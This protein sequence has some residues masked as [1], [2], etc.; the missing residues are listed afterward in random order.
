[1]EEDGWSAEIGKKMQATA[2]ILSKDRKLRF[3]DQNRKPAAASKES[4]LSY[5]AIGSHH[6][7]SPSKPGIVALDLH[8]SDPNLVL[9]GGMDFN[10]IIFNRTTGKI[11]DTLKGHKKRVTEVKFH[12]DE[13]LILTASADA[14]TMLWQP[15]E[16]GK[17]H[18]S[19]TLSDHKG[20]VTALTLHPSGAYFVT[21]SSDKS[22][23]FYDIETATCRQQVSDEKFAGGYNRIS[24]HPDGLI[25]GA[26]TSDSL[27]RIFDVRARKNVATFKGHVGPVTA[28]AFSQNGYHLSTGDEEGTIKFWDLRK[29]ENFQTVES[30]V[31]KKVNQI[32][33]DSS[34]SYLAVAGNDIKI[35]A[36]N[37]QSSWELVHSYGDHADQVTVVRFG[38]EA[39]F[40]ASTSLDRTLKIFG[41]SSSS[42]SD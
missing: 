5:K 41:S 7:H 19:H 22:W 15:N 9:T 17:Y 36:P 1:M 8:P 14:T 11:V 12:S 21:A 28:V 4:L 27:V 34:G 16:Q 33:F 39:S 24:F 38:P 25:L 23:C 37:K 35:L 18:V 31:V 40:F 3:K 20:E 32:D 6:I 2:K 13:K 42:S 26:G 29:L 30:A 10:S